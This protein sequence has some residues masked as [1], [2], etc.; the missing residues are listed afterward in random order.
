MPR[1]VM[2]LTLEQ[3]NRLVKGF[4]KEGYPEASMAVARMACAKESDQDA[5]PND[6]E[7]VQKTIMAIERSLKTSWEKMNQT[8]ENLSDALLIFK[9]TV[10]VTQ[11]ALHRATAAFSTR[12]EDQF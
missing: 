10:L 3:M 12:E 7:L 8:I 6:V 4:E 5:D 9:G 1:E 11:E 2:E